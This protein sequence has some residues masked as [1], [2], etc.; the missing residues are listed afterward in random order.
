MSAY[1][2]SLL[3]PLL[4]NDKALI[5][6]YENKYYYPL[7]NDLF[8]SIINQDNIEAKDLGQFEVK[9]KKRYGQPHYRLLKKQYQQE[10]EGNWVLLTL[11]PYGP[12]EEVLS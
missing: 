2:I 12:F 1:I 5:V 6:K 7:F 3:S 8:G 9:G 11:Y 10:N 4:I